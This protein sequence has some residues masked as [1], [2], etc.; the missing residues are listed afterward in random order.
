MKENSESNA[1]D[2]TKS[3]LKY[4]SNNVQLLLVM[5]MTCLTSQQVGNFHE[6]A[7]HISYSGFS[8]FQVFIA[9]KMHDKKKAYHSNKWETF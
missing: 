2:R 1:G 4:F 9:F 6:L 8:R 3:L 5:E 7:N